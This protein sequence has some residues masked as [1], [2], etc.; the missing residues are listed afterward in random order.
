M[1]DEKKQSRK[2][3]SPAGDKAKKNFSFSLDPVLVKDLDHYATDKRL[4]R[5]SAIEAA[6][7]ALL[8]VKSDRPVARTASVDNSL[9][10]PDDNIFATPAMGAAIHY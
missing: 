4:S 1:T 9:V 3:R 10:Q 6:I 2:G 8:T 7:T 5:S